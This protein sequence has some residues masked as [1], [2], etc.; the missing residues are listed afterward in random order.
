VVAGKAVGNA[1]H[2]NR[3]KRRLRAVLQK[4]I[5]KITSGWDILCIA[6]P[7]LVHADWSAIQDAFGSTLE[8]AGLLTQDRTDEGEGKPSS[9]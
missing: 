7:A 2:R 6:R 9:K 3:A 1:V 4:W 8:A 5:H